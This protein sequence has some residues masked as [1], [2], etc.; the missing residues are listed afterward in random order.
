MKNLGSGDTAP[1]RRKRNVSFAAREAILAAAEEEFSAAGF[2][3]ARAER[4]AARAGVNKALP[5]YHFGSKSD[6]YN[7]IVCRAWRRLGEALIARADST[8]E[9]CAKFSLLLDNLFNFMANDH[10]GLRLLVRDLLD[11]PVQ[12]RTRARQCIEPMAPALRGF[13]LGGPGRD[14]VAELVPR[15]LLTRVLSEP[16]YYFLLAPLLEE[17]G[18]KDQ[19]SPQ[20]LAA[21]SADPGKLSLRGFVPSKPGVSC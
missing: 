19:L 4:I 8:T 20:S 13:I 1:R 15:Q 10:S 18:L 5:F 9:S 21:S 12:A 3:G 7:E 2:G 14:P 17:S 16:L 6:L 11:N